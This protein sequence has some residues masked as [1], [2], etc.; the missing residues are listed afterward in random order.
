MS[1]SSASQRITINHLCQQVDDFI[2]EKPLWVAGLSNGSVI[3][4]DDD[5]Y[6]N[7]DVAWFRLK[8]FCETEKISIISLHLKFRSN[9]IKSL[10]MYDDG[11]F[12][13]RKIIKRIGQGGQYH[14]YVIGNVEF[15]K[16]LTKTYLV[17]ELIEIENSVRNPDEYEEF[18]IWG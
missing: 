8:K 14:A 16:L 4:Q 15:E 17:P 11:Y 7:G 5:R 10:P 13:C 6:G 9:I 2:E 1:K 18:I 12:F 3:Y